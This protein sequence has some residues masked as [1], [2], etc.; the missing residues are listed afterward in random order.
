[1][2]TALEAEPEPALEAALLVRRGS[3]VLDATISVQRGEVLALLGPNG[4]GKS[5]LL[6]ALAGLIPPETGTVTVTG[7][8]LTRRGPGMPRRNR[9]VVP[10][11][12]RSVGLLGQKPLLFPH[13]SALQNVAFGQRSLGVRA[14]DAETDARSWLRAVG[15]AGL[16]HR[17][18]AALSGGQQQ[19][20]AIARA[21]AARPEVLLLD[22]PLAALDVQT[23]AM[24]RT[25]LREQLTRSGTTAILVTHDV[26]DAIVLADRVAILSEGRIIDEGPKERVLGAPRNQFIAALAGLNLVEGVAVGRV[27]AA[28]RAGAGAAE[29]AGRAGG[30]GRRVVR[31]GSHIDLQRG[32]EGRSATPRLPDHARWSVLVLASGRRLVGHTGEHPDAGGGIEAGAVFSAVFPPSAV[33]VEAVRVEAVRVEAVRVEGIRGQTTCDRRGASATRNPGAE[34][35]PENDTENRWEATI[36]SLEP[37]SGGIRVCTT[38]D[39]DAVALLPPVEVARLGL[40]SGQRVTLSVPASEVTLYRR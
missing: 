19:R 5:T 38:E 9:L 27:G 21:L 4:S 1:M 10:P 8:A 14:G 18:P 13:L 34:R 20:V 30:A 22:E 12:R 3:F 29:R 31:E 7:R 40:E 37:S 33:R 24:T 26:L 35:G 36:S 39:V 25:L 11:D 16:E 6:A 23:A 2:T 32:R 15:L 17:K 28:E